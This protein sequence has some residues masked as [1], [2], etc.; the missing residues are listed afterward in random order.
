M[1]AAP[2]LASQR[3]IPTE[4]YCL[5]RAELRA[6]EMILSWFDAPDH[7]GICFSDWVMS[8]SIQHTSRNS[9]EDRY[10]RWVEIGRAID[11]LRPAK[12]RFLFAHYRDHLPWLQICRRCRISPTF[13]FE[14]KRGILMLLARWLRT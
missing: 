9:S 12:R 13:W 1:N 3:Y 8:R 5:S 4:N 14:Y 2:A 7:V 11:R 6:E 10:I